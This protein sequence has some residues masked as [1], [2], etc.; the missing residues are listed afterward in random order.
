MPF[1]RVNNRINLLRGYVL[2]KMTEKEKLAHEFN[3]V[4][5]QVH[6]NEDN[7][8]LEAMKPMKT[9]KRNVGVSIKDAKKF[10]LE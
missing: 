8:F 5:V 1:I 10:K 2:P 3:K 9:I 6:K 7:I 4:D